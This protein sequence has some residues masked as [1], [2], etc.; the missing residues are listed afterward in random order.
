MDD[1]ARSALV[2]V[3]VALAERLIDATPVGQTAN[4]DFIAVGRN[5]VVVVDAKAWSGRLR[6]A[7][8]GAVGVGHARR[9]PVISCAEMQGIMPSW[10]YRPFH[11]RV[12]FALEDRT[13][14]DRRVE[15]APLWAAVDL[16]DGNQALVDPM[17]TTRKRKLFDLLVEIGFKEIEVGYPGSGETDFA[18]VRSL[19]EDDA[20][21][22]DVRIAV[23]TPAREE[24]IERAFAALDGAPRALV[25]LYAATAPQWRRHV[26]GVGTDGLMDLVRDAAEDVRRRAETANVGDL[27]LQFSPEV[28][29]L[30]EPE[31]ALATCNAVT[32]IWEPTPER[33]VVLNLPS[34]VEISTPNAFADQIEW[35][36]RHLAF[37]DAVILSV[38]PHND[39]GTGV[40]AAEL[41]LMAGADRVEGCLFGNGER[42]GNVCLVTLALN[43]HTQGVDPGLDFSDIDA[44][45]RTVE[46]CNQLPV[47]E[48][49]PYGGDLVYTSFSGTHQDAINKVFAERARVARE[50]GV[51][52]EEQPWEV[53][54]LPI[55]PHD[56]G[57]SYEAV[58]RVNSQSG[59]GGMAFLMK[60][61]HGLDLPKA[62]QADLSRIVQAHTDQEGG[63]VTPERLWEIFSAAY[64]PGDDARCRIHAHRTASED[65]RDQLRVELDLD[66]ARRTLQG[67]GNGPID[68]FV[69]A[70]A[71]AGVAVAVLDYAEHALASGG[72]AWAAAYVLCEVAGEPVWGVGMN[73]NIVRASLDAIAGAVSRAGR[74]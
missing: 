52:V 63:E 54:Y 67:D 46:Y 16:R 72:D 12:P 21:P 9:R 58:I 43:L 28:F 27:R 11:Q 32:R 20:I 44:V 6:S 14:P 64:L 73:P 25:H 31:L 36:D 26:L 35:M 23:L 29:V 71:G 30:T 59:K 65:G 2:H 7:G 66:G 51:P 42:T 37:R 4:R 18:F 33:P 74:A 68:A 22:D 10:R 34:T 53:P 1:G 57:R 61:E 47:P 62:L 13:W 15:R 24:L 19:V 60:A 38:H 3:A 8:A 56:V 41:A 39:R 45:R 49:H 69:Q 5:G 55:D 48:R 17:D 40:A 50:T 70:L